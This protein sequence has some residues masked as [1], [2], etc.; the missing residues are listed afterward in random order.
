MKFN[1]FF[2]FIS[3]PIFAQVK[4]VN[5]NKFF[6]ILTSSILKSEKSITID[7]PLKWRNSKN[8]N[9]ELKFENS[10]L[11][12]REKKIIIYYTDRK[13]N[14][15][16]STN[17]YELSF[18]K[19]FNIKKEERPLRGIHFELST[20]K[21]FLP[22]FNLINAKKPYELWDNSEKNRMIKGV[23]FEFNNS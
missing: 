23:K 11:F 12:L 18:S 17:G 22:L 15:C 7:L 6:N 5:E 2:F 10:C 21:Y 9:L 14:I 19:S 3:I 1:L 4:I 8:L 16:R 20:R 13:K